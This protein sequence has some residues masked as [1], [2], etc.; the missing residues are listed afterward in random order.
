MFSGGGGVGQAVPFTIS[1]DARGTLYPD[2]AAE[3]IT[4]RL[5][6]PNPIRIFVTSLTVTLRSSSLPG[7]CT[8]ASFEITQSNVS[9][10]NPAEV[11][12]HAS[13]ALPTGTVSAPI[14]RMLDTGVNQN[15]CQGATLMF[16]YVGSA[17]S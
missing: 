16:D 17:H 13:V 7:G 1:G 10:G 9:S 14:I 15:A 11:A 2:G 3:P 4:L 12:A 6:N 8:R 5:A